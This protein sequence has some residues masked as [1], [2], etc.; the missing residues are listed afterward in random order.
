MPTLIPHETRLVMRYQASNAFSFSKLR[1]NASDQGALELA[2]AFASVQEEEPTR[3]T[4][5]TTRELF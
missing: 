5:I 2:K 4:L 1:H 3:I